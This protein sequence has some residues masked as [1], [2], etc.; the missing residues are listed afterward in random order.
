MIRLGDPCRS[1]IDFL[2]SIKS[3]NTESQAGAGLVFRQSDSQQDMAWMGSCGG[4]SRA[5]A[6]G[7]LR[8]F[9][10]QRLAFDAG[11][12]DVQ[13]SVQ[14]IGVESLGADNRRPCGAVE[15]DAWNACGKSIP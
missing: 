5:A 14:A 3:S 9:E 12:A 2:G 4:A 10:H 7:E 11:Q 1:S 8:H 15:L 6:D 13:V